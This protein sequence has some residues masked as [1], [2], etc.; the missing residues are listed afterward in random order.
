[1]DSNGTVTPYI[2]DKN[3]GSPNGRLLRRIA[4]EKWRRIRHHRTD[5]RAEI[6]VRQRRMVIGPQ[7]Y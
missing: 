1:M 5:R 7:A 2:I 3:L 6:P 4:K